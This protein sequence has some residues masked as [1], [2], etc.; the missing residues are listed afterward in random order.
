VTVATEH[1]AVLDACRCLERE[2]CSTTVI[3]PGPDGLVDLDRVRDEVTDHTLAVSVMLANN[4]IGVI[5][6]L[7][8]IAAIAHERGAVLHTDA[9]QAAGKIPVDVAALGVDLLSFTGHKMYGPKGIGALFV[10]HQTVPE[11]V[12]LLDGGGH[13]RGFRSGTLNVPAIVGFGKA[14][15]IAKAELASDASR[16][17]AL[18]DRLLDGLQS[19]DGVHVNGTLSARLPHN[20][21]VSFDGVEPEALAMS[22]DDLAVSSGSA[23]ASAKASPSYVLTAIGLDEDLA[24]ATLRFGL[25]RWTTADD[26]EFAI[27]KV[28][29]VVPRLRALKAELGI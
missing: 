24:L 14:A 11:L 29:A 26:I 7:A 1:K 3:T 22:M 8:D 18:R 2:G 28:T 12:P 10:R 23:C 9:A 15:D 20:L 21:S 16:L 5:Q 25:G 6:P 13:E 19:L 17:S 4:E 27:E